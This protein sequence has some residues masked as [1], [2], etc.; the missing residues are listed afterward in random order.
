MSDRDFI[1]LHYAVGELVK[2]HLTNGE[3]DYQVYDAAT[4][5][6]GCLVQCSTVY[7][8][9]EEVVGWMTLAYEAGRNET[10]THLVKFYEKE[11]EEE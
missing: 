3:H 2:E 8:S 6:S 5:G 9:R 4:C 10:N 11:E 7:L 1:E